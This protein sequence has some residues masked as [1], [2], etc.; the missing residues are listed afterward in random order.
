MTSSARATLIVSLM[1]RRFRLEA[2]Q[3][4]SGASVVVESSR[5][6]LRVTSSYRSSGSLLV[7]PR[8]AVKNAPAIAMTGAL[9]A[10]K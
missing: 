10:K 9:R 2:R 5:E 6:L 4:A 1:L 7:R 8:K 3:P